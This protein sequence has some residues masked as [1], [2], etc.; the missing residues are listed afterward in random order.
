[1]TATLGA[2]FAA[3]VR[4]IDRVHRRAADVRPT[5]K[6]ALASRLAQHDRVVIAVTSRSDRRPARGGNAATM[7]TRRVSVC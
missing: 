6:P 3:T 5:A 7:Y 1:M 2:A 4:M